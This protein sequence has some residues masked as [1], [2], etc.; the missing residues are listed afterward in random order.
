MSRHRRQASLVLPPE[1]I[2]GD[3][4]AKPPDVGQA[5]TA[6]ALAG[7]GATGAGASVSTER[8]TDPLTAKQ[9]QYS[10]NHCQN[11]PKKPPAQKPA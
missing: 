9:E 8:S 3:E 1:L 10:G 7:H 5:S 6:G 11:T 2:A 4:P